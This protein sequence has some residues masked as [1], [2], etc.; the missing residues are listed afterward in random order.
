MNKNLQRLN[1][2]VTETNKVI[3]NLKQD[4]EEIIEDNE[5]K[6]KK[7][8]EKIYATILDCK[9]IT[10]KLKPHSIK[11]L[12]KGTHEDCLAKNIEHTEWDGSFVRE[13][14]IYL[15]FNGH[16]RFN[17]KV[18]DDVQL[19]SG[20]DIIARYDGYKI[21]SEYYLANENK[22]MPTR[23]TY[24]SMIDNWNKEAFETE[25]MK[26]VEKVIADK[27]EKANAEYYKETESQNKLYESEEE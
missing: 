27:A 6:R 16:D 18:R 25:F 17:T 23:K 20:H 5:L 9:E 8:Y 13:N 24:Q 4:V 19:L 11:V 2:L 22:F 15:V 3:E 12:V 10:D 7:R 14:G 1:E 26:Q 21:S